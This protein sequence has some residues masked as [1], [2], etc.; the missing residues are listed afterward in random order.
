MYVVI[1]DIDVHAS[2]LDAFMREM[3][4]NARASLSDEPGCRQFE[5]CVDPQRPTS[6][7]LY[8][9]YDDKAAFDQHLATEHFKRFDA[10]TKAMTAGKQVRILERVEPAGRG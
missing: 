2:E 10:V 3:R 7:F 5:V 4:A 1:V 6:V 8:E 9:L